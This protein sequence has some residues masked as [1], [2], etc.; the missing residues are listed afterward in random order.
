MKAAYVDSS[1]LVTIAF[2]ERRWAQ[3]ARKLR[4]YDDLLSSNL[5]EAELRS[6]LRRENV[7][8]DP[9]DLLAGISWVHPDRPLTAEMTAVL[10]LDYLRGADLWHLAVALFV[11]PRREID[12]LTLD[13]RQGEFSRRLG[14]GAL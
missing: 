1:C 5:L 13:A 10:E 9:G 7:S 2:N 12:F 3:L 8:A 11:D 6:A 4:S 14:F